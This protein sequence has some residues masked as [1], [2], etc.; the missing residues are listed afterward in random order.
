M[1]KYNNT[2]D[3]FLVYVPIRPCGGY[4]TVFLLLLAASALLVHSASAQD[5]TAQDIPTDVPVTIET[6]ANNEIRWTTHYVSTNEFAPY[7]HKDFSFET[8][9]SIDESLQ[10]KIRT[11]FQEEFKN[12][13]SVLGLQSSDEDQIY[14][15][16]ESV[17]HR[18]ELFDTYHE[19]VEMLTELENMGSYINIKDVTFR[20]LTV[21]QLTRDTVTVE[22]IWTVHALLHHVTHNHEQQNA[23]CVQFV[24]DISDRDNLKIRSTNVVSIDRFNIYQ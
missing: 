19:Y 14:D 9:V 4:K 5:L 2:F 15:V 16:I 8:D 22:A 7:L 21:Q 10:Q 24:I 1:N 17:Y 20:K 18:Q 11:F 23:N 6:N 13:Y 12:T 3:T